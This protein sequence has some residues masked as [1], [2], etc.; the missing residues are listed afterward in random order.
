[1]WCS[2]QKNNLIAAVKQKTSEVGGGGKDT[3]KREDKTS[4]DTVPIENEVNDKNDEE[5]RSDASRIQFGLLS[6]ILTY[7]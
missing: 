2:K 1:M 3:K 7:Y 4:D 5:H 6:L